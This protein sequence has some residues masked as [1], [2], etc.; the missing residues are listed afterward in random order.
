[1]IDLILLISGNSKRMGKEKALLPFSKNKNFVCQI[2][3]TYLF[4]AEANLYVVVNPQ[5]FAEIKLS[6]QKFEGRIKFIVNQNTAKGRIGSILLGLSLIKEG[7]GVFIQNIDNPFVS[8]DL[9][10]SMLKN[11]KPN[12]YLV[13]QFEGKNGHP[14]L[15]GS[16]LVQE[17]K[18]NMDAITDFK[19][20]LNKKEKQFHITKDK[21]VLA[22]INSPEDYQK[23]FSGIEL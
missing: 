2:I 22:N 8:Y 13:P 5:N 19:Q 18:A 15:L 23:W 4:L 3:E 1:M 11:Y 12:S 7:N 14:L 6:V 10:M 21:A 17:M 9:L 20:Y 16:E